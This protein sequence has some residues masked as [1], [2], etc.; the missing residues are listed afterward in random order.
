[1]S[2]VAN[3]IA[4]LPSSPHPKGHCEGCTA[5]KMCVMK[6][7]RT[8]GSVVKSSAV[9]DLVHGAIMGPKKV[10]SKA[11]AR[12][13]FVLVDD[14]SRFI[15]VYILKRKGEAFTKFKEYKRFMETPLGRRIK[16]FRTD[17]GG[18]VCSK[19]YR[20]FLA[21][22]GIQ[23]QISAPYSPQQNGTAERANRSLS[24]SARASLPY[25]VWSPEWWGEA[26][27]NAAYTLSR[28]PNAAR[29]DSTPFE[30]MWGSRPSVK[31]KRVFEAWICLRGSIK[32]QQV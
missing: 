19:R 15:T 22:H 7:A 25:Q 12:F 27:V 17:N 29:G 30:V 28:Q 10:K 3:G 16:C 31:H 5:G 9:L 20:A 23:H 2:R 24:E 26:V 6:Y 8:S 11:G 21:S 1:M 13:V 4:A 14:W 32:A 18:E